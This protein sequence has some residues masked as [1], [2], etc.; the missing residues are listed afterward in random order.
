LALSI[1]P[2]HELLID[3]SFSVLKENLP[4]ET[5]VSDLPCIQRFQRKLLDGG[6]ECAIEGQSPGKVS[7]SVFIER[8]RTGQG[9]A[10]VIKIIG[11]RKSS[12]SK[13]ARITG[14]IL[15]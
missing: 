7:G 10:A 14:S 9:A 11:C 4:G 15:G 13:T 1:P 3:S 6:N 8:I 12:S 5:P 2:L